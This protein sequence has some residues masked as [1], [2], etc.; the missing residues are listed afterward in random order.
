[1][2]DRGPSTI[3]RMRRAH[4]ESPRPIDVA[5]A[6]GLLA[7]SL[8][9]FVGGATTIGPG[10]GITVVLLLLESLPL[11]IRR[12][13]P[14]EVF[15]IVVAATITHIAILPSDQELQAGLGILV[16]MY[17]IGERLDRQASIPLAVLAGTLVAVLL[18]GRG[19]IP[20]GLQS[21]IQ[22]ELI[23]GVAWLV[24]DTS[25][26]RHLYT[27]SVEERAVLLDREREERT[28]RAVLEERERIARELHDV[29]AHHVSVMV[30]QAGG[31]SSVIER[32]PDQA[33]TALLAIASAGRQALTDMRR[34][35]TMPGASE[36]AEPMPGLGQLDALV[37]EVRSAG[38]HVELTIE[39]EPRVLDPGLDLSAYR[40]L[41][42]GL[43]NSLK[44]AGSGTAKATVRYA[45][46]ALEITVEDERGSGNAQPLEPDH[47]GRGL[48]GMR[49]RVAMFRGTLDAGPT[50]TGFRIFARLPVADGDPR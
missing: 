26:I 30:I 44:H 22:T 46:D 37:N 28:R 18:I 11:V 50:P 10:A 47:E 19:G 38:L 17:T 34:L 21:L 40:I 8:V 13:Y 39:G 5:V 12:R 31:A 43:T 29:V 9:A 49:E 32:H 45:T 14:L 4:T 24:G 16:A 33:R 20:Q 27:R 42:E 25:R 35:V 23:L 36:A 41:Q 7:L 48:L 3:D 2:L 1:M 6:L 15:L